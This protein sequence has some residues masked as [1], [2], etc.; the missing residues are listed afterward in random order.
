MPSEFDHNKVGSSGF[1]RKWPGFPP[2]SGRTIV[3]ERGLETAAL[4]QRRVSV[5]FVEV[6]DW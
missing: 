3:M 1:A 5:S 4:S 6:G 2:E